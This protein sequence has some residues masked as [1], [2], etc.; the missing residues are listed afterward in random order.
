MIASIVVAVSVDHYAVLG[1]VLALACLGRLIEEVKEV[2]DAFVESPQYRLGVESW[3]L[4]TVAGGIDVAKG[5]PIDARAATELVR[6]ALSSG[7]LRVGVRVDCDLVVA[8]T[9]R[10]T[11]WSTACADGVRSNHHHAQWS[12]H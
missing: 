2:L 6:S 7:D 8:S 4:S 9:H 3:Q 5:S 12:A 1:L 10:Y 11:P